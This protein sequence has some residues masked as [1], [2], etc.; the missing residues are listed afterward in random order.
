MIKVQYEKEVKKNSMIMFLV[1]FSILISGDVINAQTRRA[2]L[3]GINHYEPKQTVKS[4][5]REAWWNL[6]G[7]IN[8]VDAMQAILSSLQFG[9][10]PENIHILKNEEATRERILTDLKKY[11]V[12]ETC[13]GDICLFYYSGHGSRIKNSKSDEPDKMDETLVPADWYMGVGD[14]RDKELK[15]LYNRVLD[16]K[17]HLTVIVDACHSGSISRG[18]PVP[19]RN[20]SLPPNECDAVDPP[21]KEK[22][23]AERGALIF[24]AAQDFQ[25]AGETKDENKNWHGLFTW[26]FLKVLQS[27]PMDEPAQNVLLKVKAIMQSEGKLQE[28]NLEGLPEKTR[29]SIWGNLPQERDVPGPLKV[30]VSYVQKNLIELQ[31]GLALGIREDC[32]LKKID[33]KDGDTEI[34]VRVTQMVGYNRCTAKVINGD[35]QKIKVGDCFTLDKWVAARE[36]RM[37]VYVPISD[38]S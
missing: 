14:I 35:V 5:C 31:G 11:L 18:I 29:G 2:L 22:S 9:F 27:I 16:K 21:D 10:K 7:C 25:A 20:R 34:R 33:N 3:V 24:S 4:P 30:A 6:E 23:P 37:Q 17:A 36:A 26:A 28:P 38:Y 1:F 8:D 32:E 12:D 13:P 19:L 15:K